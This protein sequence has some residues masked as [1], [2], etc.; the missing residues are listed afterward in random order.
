M[1]LLLVGRAPRSSG[2]ESSPAIRVTG[3]VAI[4]EHFDS[5]FACLPAL[6]LNSMRRA[7]AAHRNSDS[8][9]TIG[10]GIALARR[11][12]GEL[13]TLVSQPAPTPSWKEE[14]NR[15]LEAHKNRRGMSV[16]DHAAA[17]DTPGAVSGRAAQAAA[18]VAARYAK[19]PSYSEMQAAEARAALRKAEAATRVALEA[20][21]EAQAMLAGLEAVESQLEIAQDAYQDTHQDTHQEIYVEEQHVAEPVAAEAAMQHAEPAAAEPAAGVPKPA[22]AVPIS[23]AAVEVRWEPD[24]PVRRAAEDWWNMPGPVVAP[25]ADAPIETVEPAQPI[26]ANLIQFPRELV[27]TRRMR[28]RLSGPAAPASG[29]L[30]GQLSIFE[31]DPETIST[32]PEASIAEAAPAPSWTGP[33]WSSIELEAPAEE[34][35]K[36]DEQPPAYFSGVEL[37]P[38]QLRLM[39]TAVD[40]ALILGLVCAA[41]YGISGHLA[42]PPVLRVAEVMGVVAVVIAGL[43]YQAFFLMVMHATPG[44]MYAGIGLCTFDDEQP[45]RAQMRDRLIAMLVSL[46]PVGLGLAW[47]AFDEEHLSWHDRLSRTYLR[48][49]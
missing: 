5:P 10:S 26:H 15:R 19:A 35:W 46:L 1:R 18:R 8:S 37:A 3:F 32:Q 9:R 11:E 34:E 47:S 43:L 17:G 2:T 4:R 44:M 41:V 48:K 29:E 30:F 31:V 28:P 45:S 16:V 22:P 40:I 38:F 6:V 7:E 23:P 36:Y 33:E 21:A 13:S 49:C 25:I 24:M 39:A 14:V 20:Q 27:A 12:T 42:H